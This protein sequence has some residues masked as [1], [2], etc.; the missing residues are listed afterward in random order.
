MSKDLITNYGPGV[1]D[2]FADIDN[3]FDGGDSEMG[4]TGD[5]T[6]GLQKVGRYVIP[7]HSDSFYY[8]EISTFLYFL[9]PM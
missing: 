5:G 1:L 7:I 2:G 9:S 6:I 3:Q 4:L 8:L